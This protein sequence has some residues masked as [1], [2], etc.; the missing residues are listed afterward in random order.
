MGEIRKLGHLEKMV[1]RKAAQKF[2]M[3][4]ILS[5]TVEDSRRRAKSDVV[6]I[7][8]VR[9]EIIQLAAKLHVSRKTAAEI[10]KKA[11]VA[12]VESIFSEA[13]RPQK[14]SIKNKQ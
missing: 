1:V 14:R 11:M 8:A 9:S 10:P 2:T 12:Y 6:F 5:E 13:L 3:R 4:T 7:K